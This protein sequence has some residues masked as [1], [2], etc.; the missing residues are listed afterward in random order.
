MAIPFV[1]IELDRPRK[2]RFTM[3]AMMEFEE[4]TGIK[5]MDLE[6]ELSFTV[7]AKAMWVMLKQ[8]DKDLTLEEMKNIIDEY[9]DNLTYIIEKTTQ[10]I[11]AAFQNKRKSPNAQTPAAKSP[12][13]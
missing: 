7:A 8:E 5:L 1:T 10:A 2:L 9:A 6:D 3:G 11:R 13:S 12:N 4:I